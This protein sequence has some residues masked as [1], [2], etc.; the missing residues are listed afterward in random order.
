MINQTTTFFSNLSHGE[1][2]RK[3]MKKKNSLAQK[4]VSMKINFGGTV[5]ETTTITNYLQTY[6]LQLQL[7]TYST[8]LCIIFTNHAQRTQSG[9][10]LNS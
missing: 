3:N 8:Y 2:Q 7:H 10:V 5:L 9:L 6:N 1:G 4:R